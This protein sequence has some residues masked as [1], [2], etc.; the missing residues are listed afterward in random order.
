MLSKLQKYQGPFNTIDIMK[1]MGV[2]FMIVDHT[3]EYLID[4]DTMWRL[5]GRI[6]APLFFFAVGYNS[7]K[8]T[9]SLRLGISD[10]RCWLI[11][12]LNLIILGL[13]LSLTNYAI[14][15]EFQLN[16]LLNIFLIKLSLQYYPP[17]TWGDKK[18]LVITL[19]IVALNYYARNFIEYGL[20][21]FIY[22]Y[23]YVSL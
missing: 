9:R 13:I 17:K 11:T 1:I 7:A 3:G 10:W 8:S 14:D 16:I 6:A 23:C 20:L 18:F 15:K 12:P 4:D 2:I 21:G 19:A 5:F 22:A